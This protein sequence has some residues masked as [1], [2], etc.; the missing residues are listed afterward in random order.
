MFP[1]FMSAF[2]TIVYCYR[3]RDSDRVIATLDSLQEQNRTDFRVLFIDYGSDEAISEKIKSI[4]SGYDF[5]EHIYSDTRFMPWNRSHALNIGIRRAETDYVFTA[6][7]DMIFD[8]EF[9]DKL[10]SLAHKDSAT[11]FKVA[12]LKKGIDPGTFKAADVGS[13]SS[14]HALGLALIPRETIHSMNGYDEFY[15]FWGREDNDIKLR[16]D[17]AGVRTTFHDEILMHHIYHPPANTSDLLPDRWLQFQ[18]D[19]LNGNS[20]KVIRNEGLEWGEVYD[21]GDR[22]AVRYLLDKK[23][24]FTEYKGFVRYFRYTLD[25]LFTYTE[26]GGLFAIRFE[27][28]ISH[29]HNS[30]TLSRLIKYLNRL[31]EILRVPIVFRS[32]YDFNYLDLKMITDEFYYWLATNRLE[33]Q[34]HAVETNEKSVKIVVLRH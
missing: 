3:N 6:D 31:T 8:S 20:H 17:A 23:S 2:V 19:Y 18:N 15:R 33:V 30:R 16:L 11:F 5:V 1:D 28:T 27:D 9:V 4:L 32:K 29:Q 12:Y 24:Q 14:D 10:Y 13:Y 34:D 22:R 26:K 25:K 21:R 7:I